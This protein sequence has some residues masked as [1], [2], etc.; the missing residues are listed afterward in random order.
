MINESQQF[1]IDVYEGVCG[2]PYRYLGRHELASGKWVF[3]HFLPTAEKAWIEDYE[4]TRFKGSDLFELVLTSEQAE[5][6]PQHYTVTWQEGEQKVS[7]ISPYT[8]LP[9]VQNEDLYYFNEGTHRAAYEFLGAHVKEVDGISGVSFAVWAPHAQ[10]V[11][12]VGAFNAWHGLRHLMRQLGCSGVWEV[13]IPHL[14]VGDWYQFE[15]KTLHGELIRKTD[16]YAQAMAM[17]PATDAQ[18]YQSHHEWQDKAW[19]DKRQQWDWQ[20]QPISIYE[21]HL[22]SWQRDEKG[23]FLSYREIAHRLREYVQEMGF[24][25][26]ELMPIAEHPLDASWGYQVSGFYAPTSRFGTPDDLRYLIDTLHQADIGVILD[27]VP[28]H[29]PKDAFALAR[30]DGT[31]LYEHEDPRKCEHKEWGTYIFN[32]GRNEVRSFLISNALYWLKSFHFDGLRVDAVA[33]ML[34]LD[35]DRAGGE[36]IP[37]EF[38]GRE[39]LEA[40]R[41]LQETNHVVHEQVAGCNIFAEESTSWPMVTKPTYMGGLGFDMKWNMGWMNDTLHYFK[42]DPLFRRYHHEQLTFSQM[43]AYSENFVLPLSHDEVVHLKGSLIEKMPGDHWQKKANL[44]L[45]FG[46]QWTHPGKKLLFMGGEFGQWEEWDESRALDWALTEH[47]DHQGIMHWIKDL[48][49]LYQNEPALYQREFEPSG[50]EWLDCHDA[51]HSTLSFIRRSDQG[52]LIVVLNFTPQPREE[53][54]YG[55]PE[56]GVYQEV[57]NSDSQLYGGANIGNGGEVVSE[58]IPWQGHRHSIQMTLPP[59]SAVIFKRRDH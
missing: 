26:V 37:N 44:R 12:V 39:N 15:L 24:T 29:F 3:R 23:D 31:A 48:N 1:L 35:Y 34:Y 47:P 20:H 56:A 58:A 59:L 55:V 32:Y 9:Q 25:H 33:S 54:R 6:L 21:V 4:M 57:L 22:G 41:F 18:V 42:L 38:G 51:D 49:R 50:F 43:Y 27:W 14:Q 10:R 46:Y 36:W 52:D 5:K 8:F 40:V 7:V 13:F 11:S 45:L 30:F 28:G 19:L 16:P 17:R 2:D 53:Y